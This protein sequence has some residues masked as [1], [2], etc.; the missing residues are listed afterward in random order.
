VS[1]PAAL[2]F[3]RL[4]GAAAAAAAAAV[5]ATSGPVDAAFADDLTPF[6]GPAAGLPPELTQPDEVFYEDFMV[7]LDAR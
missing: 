6:N 7:W 2:V 3:A 1:P 5:L 4:R